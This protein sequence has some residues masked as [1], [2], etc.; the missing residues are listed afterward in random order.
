M[1]GARL[2]YNNSNN[3]AN[4]IIINAGHGM[5]I[6]LTLSVNCQSFTIFADIFINKIH[7][8]SWQ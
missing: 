3:R 4:H 8:L 2:L 5:F 7:S 1:Q 6:A